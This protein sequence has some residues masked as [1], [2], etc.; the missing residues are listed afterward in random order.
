MPTPHLD[1]NDNRDDNDDDDDDDKKKRSNI[2]II[3]FVAINCTCA[4]IC[5][6]LL[7]LSSYRWRLKILSSRPVWVSVS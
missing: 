7:A 4:S 1:Y 5:S 2:H 3:S 6:Q